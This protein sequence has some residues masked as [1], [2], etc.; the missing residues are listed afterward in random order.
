MHV[1]QGCFNDDVHLYHKTQRATYPTPDSAQVR[2]PREG[3]K[4]RH[5]APARSRSL[6]ETQELARARHSEKPPLIDPTST[7]WIRG[8]WKEFESNRQRNGANTHQSR[9]RTSS[10]RRA[11]TAPL[12]S[13]SIG[14]KQFV[15]KK[16]RTKGHRS[17]RST[18]YYSDPLRRTP[19]NSAKPVTNGSRKPVSA[20]LAA[21]VLCTVAEGRVTRVVGEGL[22]LSK[23]RCVKSG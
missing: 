13:T 11:A 7:T 4:A 23:R 15:R 10:R 20:H 14:V 2:L 6:A 3:K 1:H 17:Q 9:K 8:I 12:P 18:V 16:R 21:F 19:P 22:G 5:T